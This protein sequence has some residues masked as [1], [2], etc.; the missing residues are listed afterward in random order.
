VV[1]FHVEHGAVG[2]QMKEQQYYQWLLGKG[3]FPYFK[4]LPI[5]DMP[6]TDLEIAIEL[7]EDCNPEKS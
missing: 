7:I 6:K 1:V 3:P 4:D 2:V 5:V